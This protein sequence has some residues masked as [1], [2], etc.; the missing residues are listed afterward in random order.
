MKIEELLLLNQCER[1]K[2]DTTDRG[3][4]SDSGRGQ[5]H[6]FIQYFYTKNTH[7]Y[8]WTMCAPKLKFSTGKIS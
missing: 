4:A 2:R 1:S 3:M 6:R 8:N 5:V 7:E